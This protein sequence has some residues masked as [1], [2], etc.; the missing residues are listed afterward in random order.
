MRWFERLALVSALAVALVVVSGAPLRATDYSQMDRLL[1][2]HYKTIGLMQDGRYQEA[3]GPA[4][5]AL[6]LARKIYEDEPDHQNVERC[7]RNLGVIYTKLGRY[8]EA[9]PLLRRVLAIDEEVLEPNNPELARSLRNLAL[10]YTRMGRRE[11]AKKLLARA[12][13]ITSLQ[14]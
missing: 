11:E 10:L 4:E 12:Q 1:N 13:R 2:L 7:M 9:E 8:Q 14:H 5:E 6:K 3:V